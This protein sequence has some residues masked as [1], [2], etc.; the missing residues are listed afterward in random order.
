MSK[1]KFESVPFLVIL[2][3]LLLNVRGCGG[4]SLSSKLILKVKKQIPIPKE[5]VYI[6]FL[7][8]WIVFVGILGFQSLTKH[9]GGPCK[10][11]EQIFAKKNYFQNSKRLY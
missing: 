11:S 9:Y 3:L 5:H 1:L 8:P 4:Q 6:T 2:V 10:K 7:T